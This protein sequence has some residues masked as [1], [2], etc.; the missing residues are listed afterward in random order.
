M[1]LYP[2]CFYVDR[3]IIKTFDFYSCLSIS[4]RY[5]ERSMLEGIIGKDSSERFDHAAVGDKI[6]F[7]VF[8]ENTLTNQLSRTWL[9]NPWPSFYTKLNI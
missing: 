7:K 4:Q 2:H 3:G 5:L 8:F 1:A 9:I 6:D